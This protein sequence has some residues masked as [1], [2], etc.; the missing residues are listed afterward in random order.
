MKKQELIHLHS[1]MTLTQA[2]YES[3][4]DTRVENKHYA[5]VNT[6]PTSIHKKKD[7]HKDAVFAL[8]KD[9]TSQMETEESD[10]PS[11]TAD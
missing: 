5:A 8:I 6:R 7:E 2:H 9:I 10:T 4:A 11:V 1:L 3:K